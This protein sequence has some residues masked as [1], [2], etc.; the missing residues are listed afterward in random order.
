MVLS[1]TFVWE[2]YVLGRGKVVEWCN[3]RYRGSLTDDECN[4]L[5]EL[6]KLD[7]CNG[8]VSDLRHIIYDL[9]E[10][11]VNT[12]LEY[13]FA[14]D[15]FKDTVNLERGIG[16]LEDYQTIGVA[17]MYWAKKL[18]LG[19]S[20]GMGKTPTS[21]GLCNLLKMEYEKQGRSFRYL[22]LT[23]KNPA[24]QIRNKLIQ[25]TGDYVDFLTG[26]AKSAKEFV[27]RNGDYP[28]YSVC[29]THS[30]I[31]QGVFIEWLM[32][33]QQETGSFPFDI[34]IVDESTV[35]GGGKTGYAEGI[36]SLLN[37]VDRAIFLNATPVET[38]ALTMFNQLNLLDT[39]LLPTKT[40]W[41]KE[42]EIMDYRGMFPRPTGKYKNPEEFKRRCA[43]RYFARTRKAKGAIM[44]DCVGLKLLSDLSP[45]QKYWLSRS[46]IKQLVFDAPNYFDDSIEFCSANVP[47]LKS[48]LYLLENDCENADSIIIFT[49]YKCTLSS[50]SGWLTSLGISNKILNGDVTNI[51]ERQSIIDGFKHKQFRILLTNVQ[52]GLDFGNCDHCIFYSFDPNPSSMIQAEGR[53]ERS[54]DIIG[55]HVYL[56]ISR[57]AELS[58]L[59]STIKDRTEGIV[60]F[61]NADYSLITDIILGEEFAWDVQYD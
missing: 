51:A 44:E 13:G 32:G 54:F 59:T 8:C 29:A 53:M 19:D 7:E 46:S 47:K 10:S 56:L 22:F 14:W 24:L 50:L 57:G 25:F 6:I 20:Q 34:I 31:K 18:L 33:I 1:L 11:A 27:E 35:V 3:N 43:Y 41:S 23:E 45:I 49:H 42:F 5:E 17:Y 58:R 26:E 16:T 9:N 30:V 28:K 12:I 15:D 52:K 36:A 37:F 4:L 40:A 61:T 48:L 2:V 39:S 21:A 38:H 55:K 60:S